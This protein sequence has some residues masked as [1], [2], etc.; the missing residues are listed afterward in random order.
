ML[1][2]TL[3][4][5]LGLLLGL[6]LDLLLELLVASLD[7][8]CCCCL[9]LGIVELLLLGVSR[10]VLAW[11]WRRYSGKIEGDFFL[12]GGGGMVKVRRLETREAAAYAV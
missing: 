4:C 1:E 7:G 2:M 6:L 9:S 11:E 8:C 10:G 3:L 5:G 12:G